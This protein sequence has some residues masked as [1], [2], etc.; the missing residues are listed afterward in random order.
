MRDIAGGVREGMQL[1]K[2]D[3]EEQTRGW[4]SAFGAKLRSF[5]AKR[6]ESPRA[7]ACSNGGRGGLRGGGR[8]SSALHAVRQNLAMT[9]KDVSELRQEVMNE[10]RLSVN[11]IRQVLR[12]CSSPMLA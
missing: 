10:V 6:D 8:E 12:C 5:G 4:R 1:T 2:Q 9:A 11:D 3:L 7:E